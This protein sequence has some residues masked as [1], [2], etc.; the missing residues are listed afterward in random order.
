MPRLENGEALYLQKGMTGI[1]PPGQLPSGG[2]GG[3]KGKL[4][5]YHPGAW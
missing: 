4:Q 1:F 3:W 2:L 5:A